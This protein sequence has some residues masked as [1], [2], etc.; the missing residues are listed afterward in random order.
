MV[1]HCWMIEAMKMVRIADNIVN[2]FENSKE[3]WITEQTACNESLGEVDI[4]RG[5]FQGDS[6]LSLLFV[7]VLIHLPITLN[8][9]D[10]RCITS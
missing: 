2:V 9:T 5:I 10:L 3:T 4:G 7:V 6:F 8:E 1:P